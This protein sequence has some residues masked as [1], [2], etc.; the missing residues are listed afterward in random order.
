MFAAASPVGA[1]L[2]E[3]RISMVSVLLPI[4]S[5]VSHC[6]ICKLLTRSSKDSV[7]RLKKRGQNRSFGALDVIPVVPRL[8]AVELSAECISARH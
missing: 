8:G 6:E 4:A 5:E 7:E 3:K 2:V 1:S